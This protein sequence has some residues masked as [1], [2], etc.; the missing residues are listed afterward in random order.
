MAHLYREAIV[1]IR[2]LRED[3]IPKAVNRGKILSLT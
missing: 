3:D 1:V 2:D